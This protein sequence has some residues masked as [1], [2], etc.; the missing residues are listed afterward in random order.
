MIKSANIFPVNQNMVSYQANL[1]FE[2]LI[3][4]AVDVT[5]DE[6]FKASNGWFNR[7][8]ALIDIALQRKWRGGKRVIG[9]LS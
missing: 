9:V 7:K 3:E 2:R 4:D 5:E 8:V 6:L 1:I